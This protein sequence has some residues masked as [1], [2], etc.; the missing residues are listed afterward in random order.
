VFCSECRKVQPVLWADPDI[1]CPAC[2]SVLL[3]FS[4]VSK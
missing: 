4:E 3:T 2:V 1:V